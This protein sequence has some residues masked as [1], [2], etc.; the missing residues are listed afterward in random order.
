M[1]L[2]I[3]N[4][5]DHNTQPVHSTA[6]QS[7]HVKLEIILYHFKPPF[8]TSP[9]DE[10]VKSTFNNKCCFW[11]TEQYWNIKNIE[12]G[13]EFSRNLRWPS[14]PHGIAQTAKTCHLVPNE[15]LLKEKCLAL[16]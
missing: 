10:G 9:S 3:A 14:M 13:G 16:C 15:I 2:L 6:V 1:L 8:S 11:T 12:I 7:S 4:Q 5:S